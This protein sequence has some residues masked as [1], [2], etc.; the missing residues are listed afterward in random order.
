M[1]FQTVCE[2]DSSPGLGKSSSSTQPLTYDLF[3]PEKVIP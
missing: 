3:N 2:E 1:N